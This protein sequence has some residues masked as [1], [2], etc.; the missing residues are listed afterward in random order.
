MFLLFLGPVFFTYSLASVNF[1][2]LTILAK[3][4]LSYGEEEK[5]AL[6]IAETFKTLS[7]KHEFLGSLKYNLDM[8]RKLS[9]EDIIAIK[10]AFIKN[11]HTR[12]MKAFS[13][14]LPFEKK[15]KYAE[16]VRKANLETLAHLIRIC[17]FLMQKKVYLFW[18][19]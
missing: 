6:K 1:S 16:K 11:S 9:A 5:E 18:H 17:G 4:I 13:L 15:L 7:F 14:Y 3:I 2:T 12:F 10:E 8:L 19:D